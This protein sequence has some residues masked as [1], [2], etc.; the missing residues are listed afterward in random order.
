MQYLIMDLEWNQSSEGKANALPGMPFEIIE[1]GAV[2]L[3]ENRNLRSRF[4]KI[5]RPQVYKKLHF[6]ARELLHITE[7]DLDCG[8]EFPK[9]M[10]QFLSW[11]RE[12]GE[13]YRFCT[14]GSMDLTELQRNCHHYG[15]D[16]CFETP[17]FYYD[18][19][20]NFSRQYGGGDTKKNVSLEHAIEQL[21]LEKQKNFHHALADAEY[22]A[23]IFRK[24][25]L[26][27]V[28]QY[29]AVDYYRI[30]DQKK[31]EIHMEFP[32]YTKHI[33]RKFETKEAA[34]KDRA[35][36]TVYC[37]FCKKRA[38]RK[39]RWYTTNLKNYYSLSECSEHG[40]L[41][42]KLRARK[43]DDG[44]FY[45]IK[46]VHLLSDREAEEMKRS[47]EEIRKKKKKRGT[48]K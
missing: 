7:K 19:Q 6:A 27:E 12:D 5:I 33:S 24:L 46:T 39:I 14:W 21:G 38:S 40:F 31:Q 29:Y 47:R 23:Q 34:T 1:I 36:R 2:K 18:L 13:E 26:E 8:E 45:L 35:M 48:I 41:K 10:Q 37:P 32:T 16:G 9:V 11:C 43:T 42:G 22:T 4:H 28:K 30:P 17:L 20:K 25:S 44:Y 15:M 3:D